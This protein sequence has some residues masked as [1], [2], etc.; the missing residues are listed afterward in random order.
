MPEKNKLIIMRK[1]FTEIFEQFFDEG[2]ASSLAEAHVMWHI[3]FVHELAK[4]ES[5]A[6]TADV[7]LPD[8]VE[9]KAA[10]RL[11]RARAE[12][13]IPKGLDTTLLMDEIYDYIQ[14]AGVVRMGEIQAISAAMG[15][16]PGLSRA[17]VIELVKT[18][19]LRRVGGGA[20]N[21]SAKFEC[22]PVKDESAEV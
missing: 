11:K 13:A 14:S 21:P 2:I 8:K 18:G 10:A 7:F 19:R 1:G 3:Q 17:A 6:L 20:A 12:Q 5:P 22:V 15:T 4:A 9:L 16:D